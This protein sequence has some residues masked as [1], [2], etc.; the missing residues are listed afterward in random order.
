MTTLNLTQWPG[1]NEAGFKVFEDMI[2]TS[3]EQKQLDKDL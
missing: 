1:L 3:S 2:Q